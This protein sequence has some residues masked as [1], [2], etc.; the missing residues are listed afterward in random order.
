MRTVTAHILGLEVTLSLSKT[1]AQK[2]FVPK[3][4][5]VKLNFGPGPHWKKPDEDWYAVDIDPVLGD[6][7]VDFSKFERLPMKDESVECVY[8]SHVFEHMSIFSAPRIFVE[9]HRVLRKGGVLRIVLPDAEKSI[10]EYLAGNAA[11]RL[12]ARRRERAKQAEGKDL[13]LFECMKEDFVSASGQQ[14]LLGRYALAHQNAWD[15][16]SIVSDLCRSGFCAEKIARSKFSGSGFP[17]FSFEG[18]QQSEADE[19]YRSLYVEA[20]K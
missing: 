18:R 4:E 15:Y 19:D 16:E 14:D 3:T 6:V 7:V 12:F 11:F 10:R 20:V 1:I 8:G 13:T 2:P 17:Y 9:I 5:T